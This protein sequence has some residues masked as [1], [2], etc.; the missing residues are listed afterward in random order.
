MCT[1][2]DGL[3]T[4]VI[5]NY[6]GYYHGSQCRGDGGALNGAGDSV[7]QSPQQQWRA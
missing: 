1:V 6:K 2:M 3:F 4:E 7:A 5:A